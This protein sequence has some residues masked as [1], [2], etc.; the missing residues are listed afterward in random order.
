M[1]AHP[2]SRNTF[3]LLVAVLV[4]GLLYLAYRTYESHEA[5]LRAQEQAARL[6]VQI[7][8]ENA[9]TTVTL[10]NPTGGTATLQTATPAGKNV[11]GSTSWQYNEACSAAP[12]QTCTTT[13]YQHRDVRVKALTR[14]IFLGT[15]D[16]PWQPVT[17]GRTVV[18]SAWKSNSD[19]HCCY[20]SNP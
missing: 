16:S 9:T 13:I 15:V 5:E 12:H 2:G 18:I 10:S 3:V 8:W 6:R 17:A 20:L 4:V 1:F 19:D 11:D 14:Y 7:A